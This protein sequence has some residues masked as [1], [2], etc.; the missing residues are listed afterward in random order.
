MRIRTAHRITACFV[1]SWVALFAGC[2]PYGGNHSLP[3]GYGPN[4]G[5]VGYPQIGQPQRGNLPVNFPGNNPPIIWNPGTPVSIPNNPLPVTPQPP[6]DP[7]VLKPV[8][9]P[10]DPANNSNP[11]IPVNYPSPAPNTPSL[12]TLPNSPDVTAKWKPWPLPPQSAGVAQNAASKGQIA[13]ALA[14][15]LPHGAAMLPDSEAAGNDAAGKTPDS[16]RRADGTSA[17]PEEDLKYQGGNLI[18]NM[19]YVNLYVGGESAG[20]KLDEV[21]KIDSHLEAALTDEN[22]NNVL[23]QYFENKPIGTVARPSHPLVGFKPSTVSRG[24]IQ[25]YLTYLADQGYLNSYDMNNTIFNFLLPPGTILTDDD[26]AVNAAYAGADRLKN[27]LVST[28][29]SDSTGGLGGYHGS[30]IHKNKKHYYSVE[31]YSERRADGTA[32]GIPVLDESWK[33][34]CATLYH[35]ICEFRTDPDVEDAIRNPYDPSSSRFLGWTSDAGEE[36]GDF[37]LHA[38]IR[39]KEIVKEVPLANGQGM[40]PIQLNYSNF[41]HGPGEPS[42]TLHRPAAR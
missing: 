28:E 19:E 7:V 21:A 40:V 10:V 17:T 26:A 22:L 13:T 24:D 6:N 23:R 14:K 41:D 3:I 39:L 38:G 9:P 18:Q 20:W 27:P 32:N 4:G 2:A 15:G 1:T 37:P 30:I 8:P 12:P 36:I 35:E 25:H 31:V 11:T 5:G 29:A 34:M 16:D 42:P 33:N